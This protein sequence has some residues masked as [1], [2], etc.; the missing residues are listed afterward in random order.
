M[1]TRLNRRG[2]HSRLVCFADTEMWNKREIGIISVINRSFFHQVNLSHWFSLVLVTIAVV[3]LFWSQADARQPSADVLRI[4]SVSYDAEQQAITLSAQ[5]GSHYKTDYSIIRLT[6]PDRYIVDIPNAL[7]QTPTRSQPINKNGIER[8]EL[9]QSIGT[10]YQVVRMTVYA[11]NSNVIAPAQVQINN[12]TLTVSLTGKPVTEPLAVLPTP[13]K[14]RKGGFSFLDGPPPPSAQPVNSVTTTNTL[15]SAQY[16]NG[17]LKLVGSP[18]SSLVVKNQ[19]TLS[20]PKRLVFDLAHTT[21]SDKRMSVPLDIAPGDPIRS[22][23]VGQFDED[24]VRVV[25]ETPSPRGLY[26]SYPGSDKSQLILASHINPSIRTLPAENQEIGSIQDINFLRQDNNSTI[27]VSTTQPMV[28][29]LIRRG[30][31]I[32]IDLV[33]IAAQ[34]TA[35][36]FDKDEFPEIKEV[37]LSPLSAGEPN[38]KLIVTLEDSQVNMDS[39]LSTDGRVLE[40]S[41]K[42]PQ[43]WNQANG[44]LPELISGDSTDTA[45]AT[46]PISLPSGKRGGF[47]VV[48]DAGHGGKDIGAN[49]VGVYEKNLNLSVALKLKQALEAKGVRVIM[50]RSSDMFLELSQITGITNRVQPDAFVS[51][52]T[53]AS[54]NSAIDGLETYYYTPQSR[55]LAFKVHNKLINRVSAPDRGVRTAKFYVI[56]HTAVPAIL[57][58]MGYISN[59]AERAELQTEQRQ[60][61]TAEAIAQGVVE[62]LGSR[63]TAQAP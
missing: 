58:E 15:Q 42:Q 2:M 41:L 5:A 4:Q 48:V 40:L 46:L 61:A 60:R 53:N 6:H 14:T 55:G 62:F 12:N 25:V 35:V 37:R 36:M 49:R 50:T 45:L 34:P 24:T 52:H 30:N 28:R 8:I 63:Y 21:L 57:C 19:F 29:R 33:N 27:K 43:R 18:G 59:P 22:I 10:F 16:E 9:A 7:L 1:G 39:R 51:V 54:V 11:D 3:T 20:S 56:H 44:K 17:I 32:E 47:T 31:Q 38:T 13:A 23:R 26:I